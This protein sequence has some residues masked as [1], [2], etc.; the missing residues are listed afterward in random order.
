MKILITGA[1][2]YI[3]NQL[4]QRLR[5]IP[6]QI[7]CLGRNPDLIREIKNTSIE[8]RRGNLISKNSCREI[9]KGID[10]AFYLLHSMDSKMIL[11]LWRLM[12]QKILLKPLQKIKSKE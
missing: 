9:M 5:L 10:V 7:L 12:R 4:I 6:F 11:K 2:G 1:T 3:G 8:V